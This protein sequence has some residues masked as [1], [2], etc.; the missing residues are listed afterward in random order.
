[1]SNYVYNENFSVVKPEEPKLPESAPAKKNTKTML[2]VI[3]ASCA[4]VFLLL[5]ILLGVLINGDGKGGVQINTNTVYTAAPSELLAKGDNITVA[6]IV[7]R[8]KDSVV[9]IKTEYVVHSHYQAIK[10]GAGSGVIVAPCEI[11]GVKGYDII[12]N[13]HV[14]EGENSSVYAS[15]ITVTLTDGTEYQASVVG[16]DTVGDIAVLRINEPTRALTCAS[17]ATASSVRVGDGVIAIGNPLGELGG[18]VTTGIIS[19]LD[20]TIEIDGN[21]MNL[22]QTNA[23]INPGNSGG[24]LFDMSGRLIGIVNA[25]SSGSGIEGLGFAI[26]ATDAQ[27]MYTDIFTYGYVRG[28]AYIGAVFAKYYD[29]TIRVYS[30]ENGYNENVL[31]AGDKIISVNGVAITDVSQIS[32]AIRNAKISSTIEFKVIRNKAEMTLSVQVYEYTPN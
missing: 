8:I 6:D 12:T 19:A 4:L 30:L 32:S 22:L 11:N 2:I 25:K 21:A 29:G 7:E 1:M 17:F 18:S 28:R 27:K 9:E 24:G 15:S 23:A 14:I 10:S 31:R 3:L 20:R 16:Y 26:P 13:A 5:G